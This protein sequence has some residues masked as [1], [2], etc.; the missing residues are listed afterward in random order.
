VLHPRPSV[1]H[2]RSGWLQQRPAVPWYHGLQLCACVSTSFPCRLFARSS[3]YAAAEAL[4]GRL[5]STEL[6]NAVAHLL[7]EVP[8]CAL[9]TL[10]L[11]AML[12]CSNEALRVLFGNSCKVS[13]AP[14]PAV[15][16]TGTHTGP[17]QSCSPATLQSRPAQEC[18][19]QHQENQ[20]DASESC[21]PNFGHHSDPR[22]SSVRECAPCL[23][24]CTPVAASRAGASAEGLRDVDPP[25]GTS[26]CMACSSSEMYCGASS[27]EA[28]A[29]RS[30][31]VPSYDAG[32]GRM[33]QTEQM[34]TCESWCF[35]K[36]TVP[37]ACNRHEAHS[38]QTDPGCAAGARGCAA[39]QAAEGNGAAGAPASPHLSAHRPRRCRLTG[40]QGAAGAPARCARV[41]AP[42]YAGTG[43]TG[44]GGG[45]A[46]TGGECAPGA[47]GGVLVVGAALC[48]LI[49]AMASALPPCIAEVLLDVVVS[50]ADAPGGAEWLLQCG[51]SL[52]AAARVF[53]QC[54]PVCV[55]DGRRHNRGTSPAPPSSQSCH[56]GLPS[57]LRKQV[58]QVRSARILA[59]SGVCKAGVGMRYILAC[60][61]A[62]A[63]RTQKQHPVCHDILSCNTNTLRVGVRFSSD[64]PLSMTWLSCFAV[65]CCSASHC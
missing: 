43:D 64:T 62:T 21:E 14:A 16:P 7:L 61:S 55:V 37:K 60:S 20:G 53:L 36:G 22:T 39:A 29:P 32:D 34:P 58:A 13:I 2:A 35:K 6:Y 27:S 31:G 46:H 19:L 18:Q 12:T 38:S 15:P 59:C 4:S 48:G 23:V 26:A 40:L 65:D 33:L 41:A 44:Q 25:I 5:A 63:S 10:D 52:P 47:T 9:I 24:H 28:G 49:H 1:P 30:V 45:S 8:S 56:G 3:S 17:S 42:A 50:L 54:S 57:K 51:L 11:L